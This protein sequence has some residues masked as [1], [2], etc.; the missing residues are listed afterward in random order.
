LEERGEEGAPDLP[1]LDLLEGFFKRL[2]FAP[3]PPWVE[4]PLSLS[5]LLLLLRELPVERA[6]E[7]LALA[8]SKDLRGSFTGSVPVLIVSQSSVAVC[9]KPRV[10][11][12]TSACGRRRPQILHAAASFSP[13]A[14]YRS[15]GNVLEPV[16]WEEKA[17]DPLPPAPLPPLKMSSRVLK[18]L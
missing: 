3:A 13:L 11:Q 6:L 9:V 1:A 15:E 4:P 2:F 17:E 10:G 7:A 14:S 12:P 5:S 16:G 18:A 8:S